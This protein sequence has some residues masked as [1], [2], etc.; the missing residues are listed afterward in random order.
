MKLIMENWRNFLKEADTSRPPWDQTAPAKLGAIKP[1]DPRDV[2]TPAAVS[3]PG[4]IS[5]TIPQAQLS[6]EIQIHNANK[7]HE[8]FEEDRRIR[9]T[10]LGKNIRKKQNNT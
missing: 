4:A 7:L 9:D 6:G 10:H 2:K 8:Y 1:M 5:G 3:A